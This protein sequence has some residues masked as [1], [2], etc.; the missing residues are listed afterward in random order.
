MIFEHPGIGGY[1]ELW[2]QSETPQGDVGA[3]AQCISE[4]VYITEAMIGMI[5]SVYDLR[6]EPDCLM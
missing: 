2:E 6:S 1:R 5:I 4:R 3:M